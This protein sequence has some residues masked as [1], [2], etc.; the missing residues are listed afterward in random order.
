MIE[1]DHIDSLG[2]DITLKGR[3]EDA[4]F[5]DCSIEIGEHSIELTTNE[6]SK[7]AL[8]GF[9]ISEDEV[10]ELFSYWRAPPHKGQDGACRSN[11]FIDRKYLKQ[12]SG[13]DRFDF[14][15]AVQ[16]ASEEYDGAFMYL[17]YLSLTGPY[18][19]NDLQNIWVK[20]FE[21]GEEIVEY[22]KMA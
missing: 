8:K 16:E 2:L 17:Q 3:D 1:H 5:Y 14:Y 12:V 15:A 18:D 11:P 19:S 22:K 7:Q 10:T 13:G 6:D 20:V 4:N 9:H 21:D